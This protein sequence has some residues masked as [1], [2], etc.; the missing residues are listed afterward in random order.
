MTRIIYNFPVELE[1]NG[2]CSRIQINFPDGNQELV[3]EL[4]DK[5]IKWGFPVFEPVVK[6]D[7]SIIFN[8]IAMKDIKPL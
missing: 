4:K 1:T 5:L 6:E 3:R 8:T 2:D 7:D